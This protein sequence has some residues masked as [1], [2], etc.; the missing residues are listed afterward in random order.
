MLDQTLARIGPRPAVFALCLAGT[1]AAAEPA[2]VEW[3]A[4]AGVRH[5]TL[6][7]WSATG[8]KLLTEKG[9][10]PDLRMSAQLAAPT[11]PTL[12]FEARVSGGDLDYRG[13]TQ[14]GVPLTTT[15]RHTD[16]E[17]GVHGRP[18]PA[19]AWGEAWVGLDWLQAR[20]NI[21][22][23]TTAGGLDETSVLVLPGVR[24][25]SPL[26]ALPNTDNAKF[27]L[28]AEWRT[29]VR[30]RLEVDYLG[31]FDNSSLS[32]GRRSEAVL[33]LSV[34]GAETWRCSLEWSHSR[35]SASSS[36]ALYR[37]GVLVGSVQQPLV[38]IDDVSL[39]LTRRF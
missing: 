17:L 24:W 5:R 2:P 9:F 22:S 26:Y 19:A 13:Q 12:A 16:L 11:W 3:A 1:L 6:S 21:A 38:K 31:V 25:R 10:L 20:R 27:Q 39:L 14:S 35:Q 7:E 23:S 32:G 34:T 33:G 18:W 8:A 30:H 29:S 36:S 28:K 37:S 4:T 15:T